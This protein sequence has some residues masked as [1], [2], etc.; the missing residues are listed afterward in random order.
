MSRETE[1]EGRTEDEAV[2]RA[3][4]ALGVGRAQLDYTVVDEGSGGLFGLGSRPVRI[5]TRGGAAGNA[6]PAAPAEEARRDESSRR[7][8]GDDVEGGIVGPAP[9]KAAQ[10]RDVAQTLSDKMGMRAEVT[11]RDE[12]REI[13][14]V[15]GELEGSSDIADMLGNSRPPGVPSFQFLLNK[16]VNRFPE[17]R[18]HIVVEAP[19]VASRIAERRAQAQS[20]PQAPRPPKPPQ[21]PREPPPLPEDV[22]PALAAVAKLLAERANTLG[23][24]IT[25]HPM[26]AA[27]RRAIHVTILGI[28]GAETVSEGDGLYR[29]IHVVP[30][31]LG[32]RGGAPS[33]GG[34]GRRRR[35]RRR[36]RGGSGG[37]G[38]EGGVREEGAEGADEG[39]DED[40]GSATDAPA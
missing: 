5:R 31:A 17:N 32:A 24:V 23:K 12:E 37:E 11:V 40:A 30:G 29:R 21:P 39:G 10:A 18:K 15:L 9:E 16:I 34:G 8:D 1:F 20:Q 4:A 22:D 13:V 14:V 28:E 26:S 33:A 6:A 25:V 27:D 36:R 7:D 35:R 19:S 2:E 38:A 3:V